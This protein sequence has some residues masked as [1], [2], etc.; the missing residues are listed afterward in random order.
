MAIEKDERWD[1]DGE[2]LYVRGPDG[3]RVFMIAR[4]YED[5]DLSDTAARME[6][7][8]K[9]PEMKAAIE[10]MKAVYEYAM[11]YKESS[12]SHM[13]LDALISKLDQVKS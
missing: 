5:G 7:A 6:L 12:F 10:K 1:F 8:S 2:S 13:G 3:E 9:A 4:R 11:A